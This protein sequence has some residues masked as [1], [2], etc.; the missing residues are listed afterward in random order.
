MPKKLGILGSTG[1]IGTQAIELIKK[2]PDLYE[3]DFLTAGTKWEDLLA[4]AIELGI[5]KIGIADADAAEKLRSQA[6]N[7]INVYAGTDAICELVED[8]DTEIILSAI[9]GFAGVRPTYSSLASG[10]HVA[11]A[12]KESL[13]S[14]GE[15][16]TMEAKNQSLDLIAVDS[17][18]SAILQC[19]AGENLNAVEKM[20]LT[21]SGG[22]FRTLAAE[23]FE[24][25][26][27]SDALN[28][29]NWSMGSKITIDSATLMNKGLELIEAMWLFDIKPSKLEVVVHPQSIIHSMVQFQ[30]GSVKAQMGLPE[31]TVPIAY[32]LSL[33]ER[34]SLDGQRM[35]LVQLGKLD[36]EAPDLQR[37]PCL[38]LAYRAMEAGSGYC[39]A[40]NAANEVAVGHFLS[41]NIDFVHIPETVDSVLQDRA[42]ENVSSLDTVIETDRIARSLAEDY[43]QR[44]IK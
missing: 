23:R 20:I 29:P 36:F 41:E 25:I 22:P 42:W 4:Q 15:L 14:A 9:V 43:I 13:V 44:R 6:P 26:K 21:A 40:M 32:A 19:L 7:N 11:L 8:S 18:H 30:D 1:S 31:M 12:N 33:P 38:A 34:L 39:N 16:I 2:Y 10:K 37:F 3:I 24:D 28:H 5:N 35:D 17:E 27:I